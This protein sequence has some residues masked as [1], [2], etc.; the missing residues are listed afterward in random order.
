MKTKWPRPAFMVAL[1]LV[2][3]LSFQK[4]S[5]AAGSAPAQPAHAGVPAVSIDPDAAGG[6]TD[7]PEVILDRIRWF[8]QGRLGSNGVIPIG[9]RN[10][11]LSQMDDNVRLRRLG[12]SPVRRVPDDGWAPLGPSPLYDTDGVTAFSGR[13]AAVAI[14][15]TDTNVVYVGG[16]Q[17][18]IWKTTDHGATWTPLTDTQRSLAS[19]SIAIAPSNHNIIYA[20][21]GEPNATG[22]SYFGAGILKSIDGGTTWTLIGATPF[23]TSS[24]SRIIIHPTNPNILWAT[25]T[26]GFAGK[27]IY[28][29]P[30]LPSLGVWKSTDAGV[31]WTLVLGTTQTGVAQSQVH[32]LVI[33]PTNPN[34]LY[35]GA[36][37]SGV[38]RTTDGGST[39]IRLGGI[40]P[41]AA[42]I[43]RVALAIDPNT[44]TTVYAMFANYSNGDFLGSQQGTYKTV[45]GGASW[46]LLSK[47][48]GMCYFTNMTD[49][50]SYNGYSQC[51]YDLVVGVGLDHSVWIG[52]TGLWRSGDG[53]TTW[54]SVCPSGYGG[55]VDYH[56][57]AF[58]GSDV[59]I[60]QDAG[61]FTTAQDGTGW[62]NRNLG[63]TL[64]QFYPGASLHPTDATWAIGGT[65][66]IGNPFY[67]G[68]QAWHMLSGGD[69]AFS[70][71]D[72][73]DPYNVLYISTQKLNILKYDHGN[74]SSAI[75]GLTDANTNNT[76]F[77]SPF[78]MCP[79]NSQVLIAGSKTVWRTDN[80][81]ALWSVNSPDP[82][83]THNSSVMTAL[84]FATTGDCNT[85]FAAD[86]WGRIYRTRDA[87][88]TWVEITPANRAIADIATDPRDPNVVIVG[89]SG[90][91]FPSASQHVLKTTNALDPSPTWTVIS[92]GI[93]DIP[94]NAVLID[95][96]NSSIYYLGT[97]IGIFRSADG[98]V[99]WQVFMDGHPNVA[100][101]D[102]VGNSATGTILSFTHGRGVF[103]L[104][105]F[106]NDHD[107]CTTD[108][109]D[110]VLGCQHA[111]VNCDDSSL[112]TTDSC[113]VDL[114][115]AHVNNTVACDD[116]NPC[117]IGD[118]C[119]GGACHSGPSATPGNTECRCSRGQGHVHLVRGGKR[120]AVR[121]RAR[122]D[123]RSPRRPGQ[124]ARGL[125]R[126]SPG[127]DAERH[128]RSVAGH[129][130]LVR[131]TRREYVR[132][133]HLRIPERSS[134]AR[135]DHLS[136]I[137]PFGGPC[138]V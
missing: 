35:A 44:A 41:A 53:G 85:Y 131:V 60:G 55:H 11:A 71:F 96:D 62:T 64:E 26:L 89:V 88:T 30:V 114:G 70:A 28:F 100:V 40:L 120:D 87:G 54:S 63:L 130:V 74:W 78:V 118:A 121:R 94:A 104:A 138:W 18:G 56:A 75:N 109:F 21:T 51:G 15:P 81:A 77:I 79:Y 101:F 116:G 59:W 115:C 122:D 127:D 73:T 31:S 137:R 98:G 17:G 52:G 36:Y 123:R 84:A 66:D 113:A 5:R 72:L 27:D 4:D 83:N 34:V 9:A 46:T 33:H 106:C 126:Q 1:F 108:S 133:R 7:G 128:G 103:K 80:G 132:H 76:N 25:N 39:W 68:S 22:D 20:G 69:G 58:R 47:P 6:E 135:H 134:G 61:V 107:V 43:G 97:D 2:L 24:V 8:R 10:R 92:S 129:R 93:P 14:D 90:F 105:T 65:Q 124:P 111:A 45:N 82:L 112:C 91:N 102:L 37:H 95:P 117:T 119:S 86:N 42:D 125:L 110:Q 48:T 50:C 32:D 23:A 136:V 3:G 99:T 19:G 16:A 49:V 67:S 13:V 57:L 29:P 12:A 38:W